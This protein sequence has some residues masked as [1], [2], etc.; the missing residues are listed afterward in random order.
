MSENLNYPYLLAVHTLCIDGQLHQNELRFLQSLARN[1]GIDAMTDAAAEQILSQA[2]NH[3]SLNSVLQ[4]ITPDQRHRA[5][6][7]AALA[8]Q[9]DG[10]LDRTEQKLLEQ[11]R[12][13]WRVSDELFAQTQDLARKE[14]QRF[15]ANLKTTNRDAVSTGAKVLSG[16]EAVLGKAVVDR[17]VSTLGTESL[18]ARIQDFRIEALLS[19][20]KYDKAIEECRE[21]GLRD[22]EVADA[23]LHATANALQEVCVALDSKIA[24]IDAQIG[25]KPAQAA[26]EALRSMKDDRAEIERVIN[27][28]V[29]EFHELQIKKRRAMNFYTIAFMGRSKAGKSTLHA[30]VTGG[31]WDQIGVG[32]QNTTRLNRVYEWQNIRIIDTPGIATPGGEELEK[33]AESII[34]EADLICFVVTNNNQQTSEFEFLKHLRNKGKPLLVLL[35]V[36]EDLSHPVRLKRFLEKPDQAFSDDKDRLGGHI[37]RIRRDASEHYGTSN[38]PIIPVQLLA[39]QIAQQQPDHEHA[40]TL[41][42]ASRLQHFLD[43]V[44]L[45]LLD[46]GLLRRSQNLLGS[47]VA[48]IDRPCRDIKS[49][50]E[51][52]LEFSKQ[53]RDRAEESTRRLKKAQEDHARKLEQDLRGVFAE[54]QREVPD[55]AEDHWDDSEGSLNEAWS[56]ELHRFG[57]EQK[58]N[59]AQ[60]KAIAAFSDD[61]KDLLAEVNQE[62]NLQRKL[63][64]TSKALDKQ[65]S[66]VWFGK[67]LQWG[68]GLAGLGIAVAALANWWNPAGWVWG[69]VA[70][71]GFI[72]SLFESK[73]S[74]R[75]KAVSKISGALES[76]IEKQERQ[77]VEAALKHFK[78][79]CHA[80][81]E[82]VQ[83]YFRLSSGGLSFVG[84]T[85][86]RGAESLQMQSSILNTH[87]AARILDFA[88]NT[89]SESSAQALRAQILRVRRKVGEC[90]NIDVSPKMRTPKD[91]NLIEAVI[92]EKITLQ[93][94]GA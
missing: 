30:V 64:Y 37:D 87:F 73:S 20:P 13:Q 57:M 68:S 66:S 71:V 33:V 48:D 83:D 18:K 11:L 31:G 75:R 24:E 94:D 74:K 8:A 27:Q 91:L 15:I 28:E 41:M 82:A 22:I 62:I 51:F 67:T 44:R 70:V 3:L 53:I 88:G 69:A 7:L 93:K 63:S 79:Q 12:L 23:C 52:Y 21:V 34:D 2:D 40:E 43:S 60:E 4:Q 49:R 32:R 5:L 42:K 47:T 36:K 14:A 54:L 46:E 65:D 72:A 29:Q 38:F 80:G 58:I 86:A 17:V 85:L 89:R 25:N 45:S 19:G 92:Q 26:R 10:A 55:F 16:F 90:I 1:I 76:Q 78:E 35:N 39:A 81:A 6:S 77:I 50:S 56:D 9:F 61:M 59:G 84:Q